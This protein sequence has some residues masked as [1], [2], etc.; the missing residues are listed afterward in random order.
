MGGSGGSYTGGISK[1]EKLQEMAKQRIE[2]GELCDVFI[3]HAWD[4]DE[5]YDRIKDFLD[6]DEDVT[7]RDY[8]VPKEDP[9]NAKTDK[10]LEL[11]LEN[12][13]KSV[14]VVVV[15]G[16]MYGAHR[17]W[18]EK[19]IDIAKKYNKPIVAIYPW[20]SERMPKVISE[21]ADEIVGWNG[22]SI[23]EAIK[24]VRK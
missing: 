21:N 12:Q 24:R 5:D 11:A 6:E 19:E 4:Y 10:E 17:K 16:G 1:P 2:Q 13:I 18:I 7:Y 3:P 23:R 14:S 8:S 20:G 9:L 22:N 15:P